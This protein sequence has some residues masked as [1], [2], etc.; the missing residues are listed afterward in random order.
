MVS[1]L[2]RLESGPPILLDGPMGT[3]LSRRGIDTA[4]PLWSAVALLE[5][6]WAVEQIHRDHLA[7]GAEVLTTNTFRTHRRSLARAGHEARAAELTDRAVRLARAAIEQAPATTAARFVAGSVSPLEDCYRPELTARPAV[8]QREHEEMATHLEGSGVDLLLVET[9]PT[10]REAVAA[11]TA[12]VATGL[13]VL[14]GFTCR[15]DGR[16]LSGS[17][18]VDAVHA[19]EPLGVSGLLVNCTPAAALHHA[20]EPLAAAASVPIGAYGNVGHAE[21]DQGWAN[22]DVLDP[23]EY[24]GY[25]RRWLA[26]GARLVGCCCGTTVE[27]VRGLRDL[28]ATACQQEE[29]PA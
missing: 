19:V 23:A 29:S 16:L 18:I 17:S 2:K 27:H 12:A 5:A 22:T 6:P 24:L 26:V 28:L 21:A 3:E 11:A 13:P 10:I 20:L 4:L 7:A 8:L 9:M 1:F 25:A 15:E 14:V